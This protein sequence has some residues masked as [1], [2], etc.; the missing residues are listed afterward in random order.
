MICGKAA[1]LLKEIANKREW[2][3]GLSAQTQQKSLMFMN[4]LLFLILVVIGFRPSFCSQ[5][6]MKHSQRWGA[7]QPGVLYSKQ[8]ATG[9]EKCDRKFRQHC[10]LHNTG[11]EI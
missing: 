9:F 7:G 2:T 5:T 8:E 1:G 3:A 4:N 11:P 6:P 10:H